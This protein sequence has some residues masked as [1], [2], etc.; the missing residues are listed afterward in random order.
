MR[1]GTPMSWPLIVKLSLFGLVMSVATVFVISSRVE[2]FFWLAIFILC[3]TVIARRAPLRPFLH[4]LGVGIVNGIWM[5]SGHVLFFDQYAANH[6]AEVQGFAN[7][8]LSPR[9]MMLVVG[10]VIGVVSGCVL[11][12]I[13][14]VFRRFMARPASA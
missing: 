13:A 5:T 4:G 10:P 2:P 9:A 1:Y 11:G 8:A 6:P 14:V 3:A 12:L 7:A